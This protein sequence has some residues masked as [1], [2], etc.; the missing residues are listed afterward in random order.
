MIKTHYS[1]HARRR[2]FSIYS[3]HADK[4]CAAVSAAYIVQIDLLLGLRMVVSGLQRYEKYINHSQVKKIL[5][6]T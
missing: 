6:A 4:S 5:A 1:D 2:T 3:M